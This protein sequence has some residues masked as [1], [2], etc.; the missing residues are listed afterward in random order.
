MSRF[1]KML[2][3]LRPQRLVNAKHG[4]CTRSFVFLRPFFQEAITSTDHVLVQDLWCV[5]SC[6]VSLQVGTAVH[7]ST[8]SLVTTDITATKSIDVPL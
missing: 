8:T 6:E 4:R 5:L 7:R 1:D 3:R 2:Q